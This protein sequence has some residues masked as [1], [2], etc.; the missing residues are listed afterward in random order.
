M[1]GATV[2]KVA[3]SNKEQKIL[4]NQ[5]VGKIEIKNIKKINNKYLFYLL[6]SEKFY[7]YCQSNAVGGAQG[8]ISA[9]DISKFKIPLPSLETQNQKVEELDGYQKIIDGCRQVI[10]NFKPS[11]DIDPSWEMVELREV[12]ELIKRGITPKYTEN[13]GTIVLNQRCI[14]NNSVQY[15]FCRK[16]NH[17]EKKISEDKYIQNGDVLVNSTGV[18]TL[19]RVAQYFGEDNKITAD[20]H[21]TIVRPNKKIFVDDFFGLSMI[22]IEDLI[23]K[24]GEGSS[25]QTEL[26]RDR[27][28]KIKISFP[29]SFDEQ[30]KI[31]EKFKFEREII[32]KNNLLIDIYT[33]KIETKLNSIWLK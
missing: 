14:R 3:I 7:N 5:R 18:G 15:E 23:A 29:K 31:S 20:S 24:S 11:I 6:K 4:L 8:N 19:G 12:T 17:N 32:D 22:M 21:I 33:K 2:G 27:L 9:E 26:S 16:H 1:T 10:D 28:S 13:N 30:K 25:G